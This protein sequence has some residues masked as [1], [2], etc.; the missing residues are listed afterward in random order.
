MELSIYQAVLTTYAK[1]KKITLEQALQVAREES[2]GQLDAEMQIER[3]EEA[4]RELK[5]KGLE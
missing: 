2:R 3:Y 5:E 4:Y 1:Q